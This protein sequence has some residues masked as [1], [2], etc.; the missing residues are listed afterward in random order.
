MPRRDHLDRAALGELEGVRQQ[1][2]QDLAH[3]ERVERER[4]RQR[5]RAGEPEPQPLVVGERL[6]C[7]DHVA[8]QLLRVL[9]RRRDHQCPGLDLRQVEVVVDQREQVLAVTA[10][11]RAVVDPRVAAEVVGELVQLVEAHDRRERRPELVG[12]VV[13]ELALQAVRLTLG[14]R[15]VPQPPPLVRHR[16][17]PERNTTASEPSPATAAKSHFDWIPN[18]YS[19]APAP[20]SASG[21]ATNA[22]SSA[23][24]VASTPR[25]IRKSG[26][27]ERPEQE[28]AVD[29]EPGLGR[30]LS[31]GQARVGERGDLRPGQPAD[32]A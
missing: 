5:R 17:E 25:R 23:R 7:R 28:Q 10:D 13:E 31:G 2:H 19:P 8:D 26:T 24:P 16:V 20:A 3:P 9:W 29:R 30:H 12:K 21:V 22:S 1:V 15:L 32:R 27:D 11:D 14:E 18:A 6:H 4:G